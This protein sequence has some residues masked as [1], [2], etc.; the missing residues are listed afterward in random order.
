MHTHQARTAGG[1]SEPGPRVADVIR[2][3]AADCG[4]RHALTTEQLRV[5]AHIQ[6][7]HTP[8]LGGHL[9]VCEACGLRQS[10]YHGCRDRHC[11]SCQSLAQA[12]WV[13]QRSAAVL[14]VPHF[15]VVFTLPSPL[16]PV[17][18]ANRELLFGM[19]FESASSTLLLL[20]RDPNHLG[21]QLGITAVLHTWTREMLFHPHLHCIVTGGGLCADGSSWVALRDPDF[22]FHVDVISALFRHRFL[23][24]LT[25]AYRRGN[26]RLEGRCAALLDQDVFQQLL[27]ALQAAPWVTYAQ[28]PESGPGN[29]LQ[30][31]GRY[32]YRVA[33]S[34]QRLV[35]VDSHT[36]TFLTKDGNTCTL[37]GHDFVYRFVQHIL[38]AG[39]VKL[40][41]Y[42]LYASG[43]VRTRLA[44]ARALLEPAQLPPRTDTNPDSDEDEPSAAPDVPLTKPD[45]TSTD[46]SIRERIPPWQ[47][48]LEQLTGQDL[49]RC[50]RCGRHSLHRLPLP[51]PAQ[52][53][54]QARCRSPP[55]SAWLP[56]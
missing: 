47:R 14:P 5:L 44:K 16:R 48:T 18:H 25:D 34:D 27:D 53:L 21:A 1:A 33:I 20:G 24:A 7:C 51:I 22:L 38:P 30:Y 45:A 28:A 11:P 37:D 31:L 9:E 26:L 12:K 13:Q 2:A 39:F 19:L 43:N 4:R 56:S 54:A 36:V 6:M 46:T 49:S 3:F 35:R 8:A 10:V 41:H 42:G 32:T 40:R 15:H 17:V 29:L 52:P 55:T 50:P 23:C